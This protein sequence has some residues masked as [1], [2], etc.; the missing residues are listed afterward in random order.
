MHDKVSQA[1][2]NLAKK[3]T[4]SHGGGGGGTSDYNSLEHLPTVNNKTFKG[5]M[6]SSDLGLADSSVVEGILDGTNLNSF[7]DVETA[8][9][10]KVN[11][12]SGKGL[13]KNDYT[14]TDKAIVDGV[15][16][17]LSGK[18]DTLVIDN[19]GYINL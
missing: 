5:T 18:Q 9:E 12:V 15:T 16:Q 19:D 4:D 13:S 8:L 14:D 7:S 17:E 6:T 2:L 10:G 1:T 11:V 3:Y